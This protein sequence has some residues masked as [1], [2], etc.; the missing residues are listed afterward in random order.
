MGQKFYCENCG[1]SAS[2][3]T[4]LTGLSGFRHPDGANKGKH[5]L[6]EGAEKSRMPANTAGT[7]RPVFP[8]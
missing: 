1:Y 6:Y 5:V 7:K 3:I 8:R 4:S 2:S